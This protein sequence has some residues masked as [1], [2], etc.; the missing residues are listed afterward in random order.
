M[1]TVTYIPNKH[2]CFITSSRD[3][4]VMRPNAII[5]DVYEHSGVNIVY[6]KDTKANGSWI[7]FTQTG[8]AGVLLNGAFVKHIPK[9]PYRKSRG[10]V[11]LDIIAHPQPEFC[12]LGMNLEN[13]EPFTLVLFI[14]GFLFEAR[15]DGEQ[16]YFAQI[17]EKDTHI[18]SSSTLYSPETISIRKQWFEQWLTETDSPNATSIFNFHRF[19]GDG[20]STNSILMNRNDEMLTVSI[21]GIDISM[22]AATMQ[23]F[24]L[25]EN[26][27]ALKTLQ[28][29][30]IPV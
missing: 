24:D 27:H 5:P 10:L 28:L 29:E 6:P 25:K 1:C 18:W 7:A 8:N 14:N 17:N 16:K 21:T 20:D 9:P 4:S 2:G 22:D 13:I 12:F 23:H 11:F 15:W 26:T 30:T 19:A 3:E